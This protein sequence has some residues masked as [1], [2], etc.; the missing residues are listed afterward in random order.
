MLLS[1]AAARTGK[2]YKKYNNNTSKK[3]HRENW[4]KK[5]I[6]LTRIVQIRN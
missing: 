5:K 2:L 6:N 1:G 3:E 4:L